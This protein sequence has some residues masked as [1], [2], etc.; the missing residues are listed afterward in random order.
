MKP[1]K[2]KFE[3]GKECSGSFKYLGFKYK[4]AGKEHQNWLDQI[5]SILGATEHQQRVP[6]ESSLGQWRDKNLRVLLVKW[7]GLPQRQDQMYC[8]IAVS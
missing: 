6:K 3:I 5:L 1:F 4:T 2:L 7:I 8:L